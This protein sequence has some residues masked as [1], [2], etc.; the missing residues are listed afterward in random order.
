MK[1]IL[2]VFLKFTGLV[3]A[4]LIYLVVLG[5]GIALAG[6]IGEST[7]IVFLFMYLISTVLLF[8]YFS[9]RGELKEDKSF[10]AVLNS[11]REKTFS[12]IREIKELLSALIKFAVGIIIIGI[13]IGGIVQ[14]GGW[15]FSSSD[16]NQYLME[17]SLNYPNYRGSKDC[18]SIEPEN[19]YSYDTGH[20][21]GFEWGQ[22][23][24][25]CSGN[26]NSFIEGC[27]EY[28]MQEANYEACL[29]E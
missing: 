5:L 16:E 20:Y 18:N 4:G 14:V 9:V 19:P 22:Q 26:S 29:N 24:N 1:K 10:N 12:L 6:M 25:F 23:G 28:Q 3:T 7:Q 8:G 2:Q 27:E 11:I 21:A 17:D 13:V 15:L